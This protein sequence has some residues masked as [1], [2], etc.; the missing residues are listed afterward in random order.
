MASTVLNSPFIEGIPTPVPRTR[1]QRANTPRPMIPALIPHTST[2]L[3]G[4]EA[5]LE[6]L[7][8]KQRYFSP[9]QNIQY[10]TMTDIEKQRTLFDFRAHQSTPNRE[11]Q[12]PALILAAPKPAQ[13]SQS[14]K[15]SQH[16]AAQYNI[17]SQNGQRPQQIF[18]QQHYGSNVQKSFGI[19]PLS[20]TLLHSR[21]LNSQEVQQRLNAQHV[22][23]QLQYVND[24]QLQSRSPQLQTPVGQMRPT[25]L[26]P[27]IRDSNSSN[28]RIQLEAN[29]TINAHPT[30][31]PK[32]TLKLKR[33]DTYPPTTSPPKVATS[34]H[35]AF[36]FTASAPIFVPRRVACLRCY[37]NWWEKSCD[38]GEPC[39]NC[40]V[41][42]MLKKECLRPKCENFIAG[43]CLRGIKCKRAH[44]DD[45]YD[46]VEKH[47][48]HLKRIGLRRDS[49]IAPSLSL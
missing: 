2:T 48:K 30:T 41:D 4:T 47:Q 38:S 40:K 39:A 8:Q 12:Q 6:E 19:S 25:I 46:Y 17:R 29:G 23:Q 13:Y 14:A 3:S 11:T 33:T 27:R 31:T 35:T 42:T 24:V 9:G 45:R 36:S 26:P 5:Q 1:P 21:Q 44:E 20:Q 34:P 16:S 22:Q 28:P 32:V 18:Q 7:K 43:T 15:I 10:E 49:A 37:E